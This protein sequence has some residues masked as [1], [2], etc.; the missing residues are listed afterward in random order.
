MVNSVRSFSCYSSYF[1]K[2]GKKQHTLGLPQFYRTLKFWIQSKRFSTL[3][4][5]RRAE[6]LAPGVPRRHSNSTPAPQPFATPL[7]AIQLSYAHFNKQKY[8]AK[9]SN[10][11]PFGIFYFNS[12]PHSNRPIFF[13]THCKSIAVFPEQ[14]N[15]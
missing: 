13:K 4:C 14:Y 11:L 10:W 9:F 6:H 7:H 2:S 5:A 15:V 8:L 3:I 1:K 12:T